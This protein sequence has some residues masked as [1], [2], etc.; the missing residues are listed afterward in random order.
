[1]PESSPSRAHLAAY[2]ITPIAAACIGAWG[3]IVAAKQ[4]VIEPKLHVIENSEPYKALVENYKAAAEERERRIGKLESEIQGLK[5]ELVKAQ[6]AR[7]DTQP[8]ITIPDTGRAPDGTSPK[9]GIDEPDAVPPAIS[10]EVKPGERVQQTVQLAKSAVF[11]GSVRV[12]VSDYTVNWW[13][14]ANLT[15]DGQFVGWQSPGFKR[16]AK[17]T[18]TKRCFV[19]YTEAPDQ[20]AI[21]SKAV[22]KFEYSCESV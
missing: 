6:K 10:R 20:S 5:A 9:P 22:F 18:R 21:E 15:I 1:M 4:G 13:P 14:R 16:L 3:A 7:N 11:D 12:G 17:T 2:I 8:S 19:E